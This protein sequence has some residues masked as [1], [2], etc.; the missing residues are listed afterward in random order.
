[1]NWLKKRSMI[2]RWKFILWSITCI[3]FGC[4]IVLMGEYKYIYLGAFLILGGG[5]QTLFEKD[6]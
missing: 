1:M 6:E 5:W 2:P 4:W 3:L